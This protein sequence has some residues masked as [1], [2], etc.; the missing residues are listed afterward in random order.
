MDEEFRTE[1][2]E[3][4]QKWLEMANPATLHAADQEAFN[5]VILA[6]YRL[7][8]EVSGR[9]VAKRLIEAG[10]P[11]EMARE[12]ARHWHMSFDLLRLR[13]GRREPYL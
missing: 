6:C 7:G 5:E 10:L 12:L 13:D 4:F 9:Y 3:L 1:V 2:E 11:E 8:S